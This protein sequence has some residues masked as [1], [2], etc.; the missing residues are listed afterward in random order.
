MSPTLDDQL[1][2]RFAAC[3]EESARVSWPPDP[4]ALRRR[5]RRHY[6][7]ITLGAIVAVLALAGGGV[8]MHASLQGTRPTV[9][10]GPTSTAPPPASGNGQ[11]ASVPIAN[12]GGRV[13]M[14]QLVTAA[15]G[16]ALTSQR[17]AW[18]TDRGASWQPIT[19][20]GVA[21]SSIRGAFFLDARHGWA[22]VSAPAAGQA[23]Q[24]DAYRTA[25]GGRSWQR[26]PVGVP[27]PANT[28]AIGAPAYLDFLDAHHGVVVAVA[29]SS[30]SASR[31]DLYATD[32]GGLTWAARSVPL[33]APVRLVTPTDGWVAGGVTGSELYAT[34]D[35]GRG[36]QRRSL[37]LPPAA[38]TAVLTTPTFLNARDGALP[39]TFTDSAGAVTLGVY[40]TQDAGATWTLHPSVAL[41]GG[42]AGGPGIRVAVAILGPRAF[43]AMSLAGDRLVRTVNAGG[44]WSTQ[45]TAGVAGRYPGVT[46]LTFAG[47]D[48]AWAL[49]A[50][51]GCLGTGTCDGGGALVA[52]STGGRSWS[53][54]RP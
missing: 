54:L 27:T 16:W 2:R 18:T 12:D 31:G 21:A 51:G 1:R 10:P 37:P 3:A 53:A 45:A 52:S 5:G 7:R 39:V 30:S 43:V 4:E 33:G 15:A 20:S 9:Q 8:G 49:T 32:D 47:P 13:R 28:D 46:A 44:S 29:A 11:P 22:I 24:L 42:T 17:L 40:L 23:T 36:W 48:Q 19:P 38:T 35:G 34:H 50:Q 14:A 26:S 6:R 25:D 41:P